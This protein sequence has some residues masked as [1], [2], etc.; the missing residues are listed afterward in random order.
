MCIRDSISAYWMGFKEYQ[1]A[2]KS[3]SLP[4]LLGF[5]AAGAAPLTLGH[6]VEN[7]ETVATAIRIGNPASWDLAVQAA[8]ES[9]GA[10]Q[11]VSDAERCV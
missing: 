7:P 6:V 5:E 10:I 11:A 4:Q 9:N 1:A 2:G 8:Q 3:K